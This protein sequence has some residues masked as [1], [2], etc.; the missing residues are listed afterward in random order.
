MP[1]TV[2]AYKNGW[3]VHPKR[4]RGRLSVHITY[5]VVATCV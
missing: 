1:V 3:Q 2:A 4:G 5:A